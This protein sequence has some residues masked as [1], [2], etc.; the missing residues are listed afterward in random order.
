M[1]KKDFDTWNN[2]K[3]RVDRILHKQYH[4]R[5]IWWCSLGINIGFEQD[6]TGIDYQRPVL[7]VKGISKQLCFVVPLTTSPSEHRYRIPVGIIDTKTAAAIIS[8]LRL[9]DTKRL[10]NKIT[11]LEKERFE[12]IQKTIRDLF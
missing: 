2:Q 3:K 7:I 6:G 11:V 1:Y 4:A 8:Q 10:V 12:T 5:D 9:I